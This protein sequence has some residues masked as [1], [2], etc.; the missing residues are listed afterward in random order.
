MKNDPKNSCQPALDALL[1]QMENENF[2]P[3]EVEALCRQFP[4]CSESLRSTYAMWESIDEIDV[5]EPGQAMH[6]GFY[7]ML[8]D[9]QTE[10][11]QTASPRFQFD[12]WTWNGFSLKWA[13]I[14]GV[15]ALGLFSG[16][17]FRPETP[18]E[19]VLTQHEENSQEVDVSYAKLTSSESASDRLEGIQ[20]AKKMEQLDN[21]IIEALNQTLLHDRNVNVRLSAIETMLHFADNPQVRENLIRAIP[22]QTSPLVQMTLAEVMIAL[23]DKRAVHEIQELL[24][25]QQLELEVQMKMEETIETLL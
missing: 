20:M 6:A 17:F 19:I 11:T 18:Q 25:E 7:K 14:A 15:F 16:T 8:N 1:A 12:W 4:D 2:Q 21:R 23:K 10:T 22:H 24:Q 13:V 3:A 9:F 5:P